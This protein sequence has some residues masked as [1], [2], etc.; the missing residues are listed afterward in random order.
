MKNKFNYRIANILMIIVILA[1]VLVLA[2]SYLVVDK[3]VKLLGALMPFYLAFFISWL[4]KPVARTLN[5]K[6]KI[7]KGLSNFL[8]VLLNIAVVAIVV[9]TIIP[10]ALIQMVSLINIAPEII[11]GLEN[12]LADGI[13]QLNFLF[14]EFWNWIV[15]YITNIDIKD[16]LEYIDIFVG[17]ISYLVSTVTGIISVILQIIIA[18]VISFYFIGDIN[19]FSK[20][21]LNLIFKNSTNH[22]SIS[23]EVSKTLFGYFRGLLVVCTFVT[24]LVTIGCII[25]GIPSPLL[26]GV[27]AGMT[28][29]IPYIGP[30]VGGIPIIIVA[31]SQSFFTTFLAVLVVFGTQFIESNFL[32]P[33]IMSKSTNLHP[34]SIIVGLIIFQQLFGLAGMIIAT[35]TLAVLNVII[36]HSKYDVSL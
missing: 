28:N 26:F 10:A 20:K 36:K 27:I 6:F 7:S 17:S 22:L 25:I 16:F 14:P 4:M 34:V 8:A 24:V 5:K 31:L 11:Q 21:V 1:I 23:L 19:K 15:T 9:F 13:N 35:P 18:Y 30:I 2:E 32:Q 33:K 29:V 12:N 3:I